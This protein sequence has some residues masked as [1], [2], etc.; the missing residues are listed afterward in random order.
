MEFAVLGDTV[1]VASRLEGL[2]RALDAAAVLSDAV[3][4]RAGGPSPDMRPHTGV[5][6]PKRAGPLDLWTLPRPIVKPR[7]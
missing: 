4:A 5:V 7:P 6:L 3:L 1:K 2:C